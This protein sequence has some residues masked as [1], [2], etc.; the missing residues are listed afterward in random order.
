MVGLQLKPGFWLRFFVGRSF[1]LEK[2]SFA[3]RNLRC[4]RPSFGAGRDEVAVEECVRDASL[5]VFCGEM[6]FRS[7]EAH[8]LTAEEKIEVL[9]D[10]GNGKGSRE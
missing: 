5:D 3:T 4:Q 1:E 10:G 8:L 2:A 6:G 7:A 9:G